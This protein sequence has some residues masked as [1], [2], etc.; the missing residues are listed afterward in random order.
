M[1]LRE[2]R[3]QQEADPSFDEEQP[4]GAP[5]VSEGAKR[6]F[7]IVLSSASEAGGLRLRRLL[8]QRGF[9]RIDTVSRGAESDAAALAAGIRLAGETGAAFVAA[10]DAG[11]GCVSA[12]AELDG[13]YQQLTCN[14]LSALLLHYLIERR[15]DAAVSDSIYIKT[16]VTGDL[17]SAIAQRHGVCVLEEPLGFGAAGERPGPAGRRAGFL[18]V[19]GESGCLL[20]DA[21]T[22]E[23]SGAAAAVRICE[24][25]AW[26]G[27]QGRSLLNVLNDLYAAYGCYVSRREI[28]PSSEAGS[29]AVMQA[30]RQSAPRLCGE[31]GH[32]VDYAAGQN[33]SPPFDLVKL[34]YSD[35]CWAAV[36][37]D[38][39]GNAILVRYGAS[40]DAREAA[41]E[42]IRLHREA[43]LGALPLRGG[44]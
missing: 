33:G 37:P 1:T 31:N 38:E 4:V 9:R 36:G 42:A 2:N 16:P 34:F 43:L 19:C 41:E 30:L 40:G 22:R 32:A 17:G 20:A 6:S 18:L 26:Y 5:P 3:K 35:G 27:A 44:C 7:G 39:T 8:A 13:L 10:L 29:A 14:Q 21:H 23:C 12:A 25:A 15:G 24:M 28:C 11:G